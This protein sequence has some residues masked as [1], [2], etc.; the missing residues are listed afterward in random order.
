MSF[1]LARALRRIGPRGGGRLDARPDGALP[2]VAVALAG[3]P[4]MLDTTVHL[5]VLQGATPPVI[6]A[7]LRVRAAEHSSVIVAELTHAFGRLDPA[8]PGTAT[9][10][11]ELRGVIADMRPHRTSSPGT[12][13]WCEAGMLAGAVVR[14]AGF[15]KTRHPSLL[16]DALI[17]LHAAERGAVV[18]TGNVRDFDLIDQIHGGGHLL[19]YRQMA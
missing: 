8:H 10:L 1:D 14:R 5:D 13:V 2:F 3:K 7:L 16:N 19:L 18:L 17:Y 6:D 9:A 15:D 12:Q 4:L 11:A